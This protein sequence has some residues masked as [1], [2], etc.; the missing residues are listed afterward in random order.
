[1]LE[2]ELNLWAIYQVEP[3]F[4]TIWLVA[5]V[6]WLSPRRFRFEECNPLCAKPVPAMNDIKVQDIVPIIEDGGYDILLEDKPTGTE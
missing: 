2:R 1:M 4:V 5:F 6:E 3:K